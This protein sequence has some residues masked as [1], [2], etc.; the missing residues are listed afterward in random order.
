[1]A[2]D[3]SDY[4]QLFE[5]ALR[6]CILLT[7][8]WLS[9]QRQMLEIAIKGLENASHIKPLQNF[10][11]SELQA[12]TMILDGSRTVRDL[13]D[14]DFEKK[15]QDTFKEMFP[16]FASA[17]VQSLQAQEAILACVSDALNEL[18]KDNKSGSRPGEK[19][20]T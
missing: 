20:S 3:N 9:L 8:P 4:P 6:S 17:S 2:S 19:Q 14:P 7:L 10:T 18:R 1:M 16:K 11:L 15:L 13:V 5:G 12:L